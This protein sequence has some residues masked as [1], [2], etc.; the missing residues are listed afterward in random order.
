MTAHSCTRR[1]S[2]CTLSP[3]TS[4]LPFRQAEL[5]LPI[6]LNR[7]CATAGVVARSRQRCF[8]ETLLQHWHFVITLH[9]SMLLLLLLAQAYTASDGLACHNLIM[10]LAYCYSTGLVAADCMYR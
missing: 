3:P 6:R 4:H 2:G 9:G 7:I 5:V 8:T 1:D 10:T